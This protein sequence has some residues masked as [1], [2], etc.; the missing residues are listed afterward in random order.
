MKRV[1]AA[2]LLLAAATGCAGDRDDVVRA[3]GQIEA[4]EVRLAAKVGGI[5]ATVTVDEGDTVTAGQVVATLDTV[6][7][8]LARAQAVAERAQAAAQLALLDAGSRSEDIA[9]ARAEVTLRRSDFE[10]AERDFERAQALFE[11]GAIAAQARDDAR[12][13][14]DMARAALRQAEEAARRVARGPR[15]EEK[16]AARAALARA[17]AR[18]EAV[19]QQVEDATVRAPSSGTVTERLVEPGELVTPGS[20]LLVYADVTRPWLTA[21]VTGEDLPRVVIGADALVTT[22]A[23]GDRGRP[24]K[25][26]AISPTAEFTPRNVQTRDERARLVHRVR[27][28]VDNRDGRFKPGM[29]ADAAIETIPRDEDQADRAGR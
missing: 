12:A 15:I 16:A 17:Q 27:I 13:R 10:N 18:L 23:R 19:A 22:D 24:G 7:L 20:G 2:L 11:R 4:T 21:F 25:V 9:S 8:A 1:A 6:D 29:S 14:Q 3:S 26:A 5:V 28:R